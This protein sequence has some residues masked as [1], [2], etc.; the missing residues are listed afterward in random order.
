MV[1]SSVHFVGNVW[2]KVFVGGDVGATD[3]AG[4]AG[5]PMRYTGWSL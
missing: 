1:W 2:L 3:F 5:C 4:M